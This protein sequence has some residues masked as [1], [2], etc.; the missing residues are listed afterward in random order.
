MFLFLLRDTLLD[1]KLR[2]VALLG[3]AMLLRHSGSP[4]WQAHLV[5]RT[6]YGSHQCR[7]EC[8]VC[9]MCHVE[10]YAQSALDARHMLGGIIAHPVA[11]RTRVH[12]H[13]TN[14][15]CQLARINL[16]GA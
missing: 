1:D 3:L 8:D 4:E 6:T 5:H 13:L 9:G 12:I 11:Q 2:Q 15:V 14:Q 16:H 7:T 10:H